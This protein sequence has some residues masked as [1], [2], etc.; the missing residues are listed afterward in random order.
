MSARTETLKVMITDYKNNGERVD[1]VLYQ[2]V[3]R[4]TER[5][6]EL[7]TKNQ[8]LID[9]NDITPYENEVL[10]AENKRLREALE[11]YAAEHKYEENIS[12]TYGYTCEIAYDEGKTARQ[13]LEGVSNGQTL[14]T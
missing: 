4:V 9:M 12:T 7:E 6:Q 10:K 8:E 14:K 1:E 11:F 3:M 5:S 13:A 2:E